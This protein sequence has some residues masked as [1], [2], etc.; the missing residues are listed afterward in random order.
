MYIN[1]IVKLFGPECTCK[2]Y[3]DDL[4]FYSTR[5]K[6]PG[7]N[8]V[9]Q[10]S[11]DKL[12]AWSQTWQLSIS[13]K[14][15]CVLHV[16]TTNQGC[17]YLLG[18]E[19]VAVVKYVKD[20]GIHIDSHLKFD[21]HITNIVARASTRANLIHKCFV[22]KDVLAL[23]RAFVTY[24]RPL[25]EYTSCVWSPHLHKDIQRIESVQRRFT[26]RLPNM[27]YLD[28]NSRIKAL[29]LE[30]LE[31]RRLQQDLI[32]TYKIL[33]NNVSIDSAKLFKFWPN[34]STRGHQWKLFPHYS[35]SDR[36]KYFFCNRVIAPWNSLKL[37]AD[38]ISSVAKF[39]SFIRATDLSSFL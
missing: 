26:K 19:Q 13:Y 2:L 9:I 7:D 16:N 17:D 12:I 29:G 21:S 33:F 37:T 5:V 39:K 6:S 4:K 10:V 1:D 3:A 24:V 20:L 35:R 8:S 36:R 28:Y 30:N 31:L 22:S 14:K 15:C 18:T 27:S 23:N 25:L 38:C 34:S 32:Y 11:L